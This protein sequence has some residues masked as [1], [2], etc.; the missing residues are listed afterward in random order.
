[1]CLL[2]VFYSRHHIKRSKVG[3]KNI[4]NQIDILYHFVGVK[5]TELLKVNFE[6]VKFNLICIYY[7]MTGI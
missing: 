3:F 6:T 5:I 2:F 7:Q 1:M 4:Q